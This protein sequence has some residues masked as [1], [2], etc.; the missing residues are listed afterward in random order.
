LKKNYKNKKSIVI[1][2]ITRGGVSVSVGA[3]AL[4]MLI[5]AAQSMQV[6]NVCGESV[7]RRLWCTFREVQQDLFLS[8][9]TIG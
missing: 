9:L 6:R 4:A 8:C 2:K 5:F 1:L 3:S 7:V